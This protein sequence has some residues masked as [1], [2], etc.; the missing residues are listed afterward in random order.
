[1]QRTP[2]I[3]PAGR[4]G[5]PPVATIVPR[6]GWWSNYPQLGEEQAFA[7]DANSRQTILKAD[8]LGPP[9]VYTITLGIAYSEQ[10]WPGAGRAFEVEAEI[11]FGAGGATQV[12]KIDWVQGAQISLPMNAVNVI[13]TYNID[14]AAAPR[15]PADLR[16]SAM[17]GRGPALGKSRWTDPTPFPLVA[18]GQTP[19]RRIAAFA[20]RIWV[21]AASPAG[22]DLV[23]T[24]GNFLIF[25]GGPLPGDEQVAS[26]R[27]DQYLNA[28]GEGIVIPGQAKYASIFNVSGSTVNA[29]A[30]FQYEIF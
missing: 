2:P 5:L 7:P 8:E 19:P 28:I 29:R 27:L 26:V 30:R 4:A 24:A 15:P 20:S 25:Q 21:I 3:A 17:V 12:V 13:A 14:G 6:Q 9:E 23:F 22:A 10:D 1:M 16:L 11:N 18:L